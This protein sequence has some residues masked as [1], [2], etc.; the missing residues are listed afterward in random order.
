MQSSTVYQLYL[1]ELDFICAYYYYY[2]IFIIIIWYFLKGNKLII[3]AGR[4]CCNSTNKEMRSD[5]KGDV[6][7]K[8]LG[9]QN[10]T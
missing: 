10:E 1:K 6:T 4:V 8:K 5:L 9:P 7:F 2:I 3:S